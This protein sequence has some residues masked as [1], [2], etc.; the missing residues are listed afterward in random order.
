MSKNAQL[1]K[2]T[3]KWFREDNMDEARFFARWR[4]LLAEERQKKNAYH[5]KYR[6]NNL[7]KVR[8]W[9]RLNRRE[10]RKKN[11]EKTRK[12]LRESYHRHKEQRQQDSR[13]QYA[14]MMLDPVLHAE[15][16]RK[17]RASIAHREATDL[18]FKLARRIKGRVKQAFYGNYKKSSALPLLGCSIPEFRKHLESL[19][20]EGMTWENYGSKGWEIDHIRPCKSFDLTDPE[21][22]KLCF[23][24]SN[25]RPMW[26]LKNRMK[27]A[28]WNGVNFNSRWKGP[29]V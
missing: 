13:K 11:P 23:H 12:L 4:N 28:V 1:V 25:T 17:R 8:T 29:P 2:R 18:N 24:Y 16:L 7:E 22:Q 27:A 15:H 20:T 3:F 19:W 5:R 14:K 10:E 9:H 21:Q 6:Q 26:G